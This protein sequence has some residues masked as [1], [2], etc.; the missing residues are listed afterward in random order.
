[1]L[2]SIYY[3]VFS[4]I[5][6]FLLI[7]FLFYIIILPFRLVFILFF[8][9]KYIS[10]NV[11]SE[12][13]L[14]MRFIE[15]FFFLKENSLIW[16]LFSLDLAIIFLLSF[17]MTFFD[18]AF[19]NLY[20]QINCQLEILI[21]KTLMFWVNFK[22]SL[23]L[24]LAVLLWCVLICFSLYFPCLRVHWATWIYILM[25][26]IRFEN[27]WPLFLQLLHLLSSSSSLECQFQI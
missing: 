9:E 8:L 10:K 11:F 14:V 2:S 19:H 7:F 24:F 6:I 1:M 3:F 15:F 23:S 17:K 22:F 25:I 21:F 5:L 27:L 20:Y 18:S 4:H 26:S 16:R 13:L 12:K